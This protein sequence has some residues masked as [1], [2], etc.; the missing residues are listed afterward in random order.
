MGLQT[1]PTNIMNLEHFLDSSQVS[2]LFKQIFVF[3][4]KLMIHLA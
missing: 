3:I 4:L 1:G 2:G